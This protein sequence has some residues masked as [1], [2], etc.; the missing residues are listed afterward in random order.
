LNGQPAANVVQGNR[1]G[2]DVSGTR[3]LGNDGNGI[4]INGAAGNL[5]GGTTLRDRN[6]IAG[7]RGAGVLIQNA[8]ADRNTVANNCIGT[9][10]NGSLALGNQGT[11]VVL[12]SGNGNAI[13]GAA[14]GAG[15][16]IAFNTGSGV[17]LG[18]DGTGNAIRG[19]AIH[20][21][22]ALGINLRPP[23]E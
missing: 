1:I 6:V 10:V 15:N 17:F 2:V 22:G 20:S 16:V 12:I 8:G 9:D 3:S 23:T 11:G 19:N 4:A 18:T 7:N 21:N 13:G 14:A 5:L